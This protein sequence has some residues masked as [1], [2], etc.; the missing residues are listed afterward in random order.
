MGV[1]TFF[2]WLVSKFEE[3][4]L[5]SRFPFGD[6]PD[7]LYIDL[8]CAIHPAVKADPNM[9][10]SD[11]PAAVLTYLKNIVDFTNPKKLLFIAIDGVAPRAKMEQQR[12]RRYKSVRETKLVR[13][14]KKRYGRP[15]SDNLIDFNMISPGT[16]FMATLSIEIENYINEMLKTEWKDLEIHLSD[17]SVPGEGE[18][19]IMDHIRKYGKTY[20]N[21][22]IY[23]LDS[24]LIFLSMIN[25]PCPTALVRES[26]QFGKHTTDMTFLSI[27]HLKETIVSIMSPIV[28]FTELEGVEI[29][30]SFQFEPP[31]I[32][33]TGFYRGSPTDRHKLV[34]DYAFI[35]FLL[36]NDFVPHIPSLSIRDGGLDCVIQAYK[37][38][39]WRLGTFLVGA[40]GMTVSQKFLSQLLKELSLIE[41][42]LLLEAE[43]HKSDRVER[44]HRKMFRLEPFDREIE[45]MNYVENKY[46]D[47]VRSGTDGWRSRYYQ[48]HFG[49]TSRN[50]VEFT[51]HV[52][53]ISVKFL[54]GMMWTLLY[55]QGKHNNWSWWY[56]YEEAPTISD[57]R[58][59]LADI[60]LNRLS[61]ASDG[62]VTPFVQLLA[63]LPPES[64]DLL[65]HEVGSIMTT[66]S[67]DFH[68]MYPLRIELSILGKRFLWECKPRL[69]EIDIDALKSVVSKIHTQR[70]RMLPKTYNRNVFGLDKSWKP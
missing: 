64:A 20:Q 32:C 37:V 50:H 49:I 3:L 23:G 19:K 4:M 5:H 2:H 18:H 9:K 35:C 21:L 13:E 45:D 14:I 46:T 24:D 61:F 22:S 31:P 7:A 6:A 59:A 38:V 26:V 48:H 56:C 1:P 12:A 43:S 47:V 70:I 60:D 36:G 30:N 65:P 42:R 44:F 25:C 52:R 16:E 39:S 15:V 29:F 69:P 67:S 63:I 40:D 17:A 41:D 54:E 33:Q 34:I 55:Y 66:R 53:P 68:Y 62:P 58:N 57:L 51:A 10:L 28:N 8:N 27:D 11:M